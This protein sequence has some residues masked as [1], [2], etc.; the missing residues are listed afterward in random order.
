MTNIASRTKT[1]IAQ[2]FN[3]ATNTY[4]LAADVQFE[5]DF[6]AM[7]YVTPY[8]KCGLDIGCGSGI[9]VLVGNLL[10]GVTH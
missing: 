10:L 6:D 2:Q 5:I 8:F 4:D 7:S 1:R 9:I 3:C